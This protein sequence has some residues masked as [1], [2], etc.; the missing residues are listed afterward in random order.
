MKKIKLGFI[1]LGFV[2]QT[3][4]LPFYHADKRVE[5]KALCEHNKKLL[6]KVS[7]KYNIRKIYSSHKQMLNNEKLDG[8]ILVVQRP[9]IAKTAKD[10]LEKG[11]SLLSEKPA[12]LNYLTAKELCNIAKKKNTKYIIGYMKRHDNG[13]L[14]LKKKLIKNKFGKLI[15]VYYQSFLGNP[16]SSS[17]NYFKHPDRKKKILKKEYKNKKESFLNFLNI[18]SHT[19]NLIRHLVGEVKFYHKVLSN[20]GEGIVLLKSIISDVKVVLNNQ[21][22]NRGKWIE[23]I[24]LNFQKGKILIKMPGPLVKNTTAQVFFDNYNNKKKYQASIR[25]GWSFKNQAKFFV[26]YLV[27]NKMRKSQC[28]GKN[29][30]AD[31]KII[32]KIFA[33]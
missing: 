1:G 25:N 12:A 27:S 20:T 33:N 26:D 11:V 31:I 21:S 7:K 9:K 6:K 15:S 23:N 22:S 8:V 28:D 4:H 24:Y 16:Y 19:I 17:L 10:V 29:S 30:L 13:I 18:H 14:F 5:I 3:A 32:E 2:S